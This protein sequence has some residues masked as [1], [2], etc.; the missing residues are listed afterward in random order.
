MIPSS[1]SLALLLPF[2]VTFKLSFVPQAGC[3]A[4]RSAPLLLRLRGGETAGAYDVGVSTE[5]RAR[6]PNTRADRCDHG[7]WSHLQPGRPPKFVASGH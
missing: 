1:R 5:R 4:C 2:V 7:R 6:R 3:V